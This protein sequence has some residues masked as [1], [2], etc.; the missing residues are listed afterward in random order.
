MCKVFVIDVRYISIINNI[1]MC[2]DVK[3]V[4]LWLCF[5]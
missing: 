4:K 3:R 5:C 1:E 2:D